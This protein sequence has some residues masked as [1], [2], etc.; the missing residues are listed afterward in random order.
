M[1]SVIEFSPEFYAMATAYW[2]VY[3][4]MLI[5]DQARH[6]PTNRSPIWSWMSVVSFRQAC[7]KSFWAVGIFSGGRQA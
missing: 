3:Q 7:V 1:G 5:I 6:S 4:P 2:Q